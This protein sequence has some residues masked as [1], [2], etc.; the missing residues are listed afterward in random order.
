MFFSNVS[1]L[2]S[3]SEETQFDP[4]SSRSHQQYSVTCAAGKDHL[5]AGWRVGQGGE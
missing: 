5:A 1:Y 3:L 4:E 2:M